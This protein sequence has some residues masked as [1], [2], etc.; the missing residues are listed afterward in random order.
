MDARPKVNAAANKAR[1]AGYETMSHY[2]GEIS[3]MSEDAIAG[4][5][6]PEDAGGF[7]TFDAR[8][9][10]LTW[11]WVGGWCSSGRGGGPRGRNRTERRA[12][13]PG[14]R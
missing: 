5:H 14:D 12:G 9:A 2:A 6:H 4:T 13:V 1:G 11:W 3:G 7:T 8:I 10:Q